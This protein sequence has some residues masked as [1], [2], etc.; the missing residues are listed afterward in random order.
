[1]RNNCVFWNCYWPWSPLTTNVS[2]TANSQAPKS[3]FPASWQQCGLMGPVA[4]F[5]CLS[6]VVLFRRSLAKI[7]NRFSLWIFW[8]LAVNKMAQQVIAN[9]ASSTQSKLPDISLASTSFWCQT[10]GA[11]EEFDFEWTIERLAFFMMVEYGNHWRRPIFLI[12][13]NWVSIWIR[14]AM[15]K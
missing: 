12:T 14:N 8:P 1:M 3:R 15:L 11:V 7:W 4:V 2:K 9:A 10:K 5:L 13:A 6:R